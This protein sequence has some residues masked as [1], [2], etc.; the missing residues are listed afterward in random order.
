[1]TTTFGRA[2]TTAFFLWIVCTLFLE[3]KSPPR[4]RLRR[5]CREKVKNLLEK[6]EGEDATSSSSSFFASREKHFLVFIVCTKNVFASS[7]KHTQNM[8]KKRVFFSFFF[9]SISLFFFLDFY[10]LWVFFL[11]AAQ[12]VKKIKTTKSTV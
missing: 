9:G 8:T 6:G 7:K 10:G 1:M 12:I 4:L 5:L 2:H 11:K 3:M